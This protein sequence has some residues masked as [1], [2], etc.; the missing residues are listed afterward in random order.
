MFIH[1]L[2]PVSAHIANEILIIDDI[3]TTGAT[4]RAIVAAIR[5]LLSS[6]SIRIFT[7]ASTD[8]EALINKSVQLSGYNYG[9]QNARGWIVAE[10]SEE[11]DT[12]FNAS[13]PRILSDGF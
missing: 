3:L 11:V 4:M 9:W 10:D 13:K 5:Q 12:E 8:R 2:R 7:L 6:T 1:L